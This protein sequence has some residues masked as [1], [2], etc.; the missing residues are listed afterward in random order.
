MTNKFR[1]SILVKVAVLSGIWAF[2]LGFALK[3]WAADG[4]S[5][6]FESL[7]GA[8][9]SGL[10]GSDAVRG[11]DVPETKSLYVVPYSLRGVL[12][13][14]PDR[15]VLN[16]SDGRVFELKISDRQARRFDGKSVEVYAKA[17]EADQLSVLEVKKISEY[18]PGG[19]EVLKPYIAKQRPA[20]MVSDD[21]A[22]MTF[23]NVRW[24]NGPVEK[25]VFDWTTATV[26][27]DLVKNVYFVKKPFAPEWIA[28]HSFMVFTFSDGGLVDAAGRRTDAL[29]LSI[30]AYLRDG[31]SYS[32]TDGMKNKFSIVWLLTTWEDYS[33][34]STKF[35][36]SRLVPYPVQLDQAQKVA[37]VKESL[38]QAA[39]NRE[40]EFYNTITNNCTNNLVILING[41]LPEDRRVKMWTIPSLVYNFDSTMPVWVPPYL[42]KKGL[43]GPELP[44]V[45]QASFPVVLP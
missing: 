27:P 26:R 4:A 31:Q 10:A 28:A 3:A 42:Q 37:L 19:D 21:G 41:V 32:L 38:R 24:N 44:K 2:L 25:D 30:E 12:T 39:V 17:K 33:A 40:G 11:M 20:R 16:T 7:Y 23:E 5:A 43:L 18:R 6:S 45:D 14:Y 29:V 36:A 22:A 8:D 1:G 15:A 34:R 35:D 13:R 9:L